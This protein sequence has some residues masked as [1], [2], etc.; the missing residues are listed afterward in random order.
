MSY[1]SAPKL[2]TTN[3]HVMKLKN[4]KVATLAATL[5]TLGSLAG[6]ANAAI[7]FATVNGDDLEVNIDAPI[8]FNV[9]TTSSNSGFWGIVLEDVYTSDQTDNSTFTVSATSTISFG[10][11][12]STGPILAGVSTGVGLPGARDIMLLWQTPSS[13]P[14]AGSTVTVSSGK[15]TIGDAGATLPDV[16]GNINAALISTASFTAQGA[17]TTV[18]VVPEPS[19]ALLLGFGALG[20]LAR[21]R[22][23]H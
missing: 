20:V 12:T 17:T 16:T 22:R 6:G 19:S 13:A 2:G 10:A 9:T 14:T 4:K 7:T 21:R 1:L 8:T 15:Y 11:T 18:S 3:N 5:I 23:A